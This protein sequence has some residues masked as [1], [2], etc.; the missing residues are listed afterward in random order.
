MKKG[1]GIAL[2]RQTIL[3]IL[4]ILKCLLVCEAVVGWRACL[5]AARPGFELRQRETSEL[6]MPCKRRGRL[7]QT[8][9]S[10]ERPSGLALNDGADDTVS[11]RQLLY[12]HVVR[13]D[14]GPNP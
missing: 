9:R 10:A 5:L 3:K 1:S 6:H 2:Q 13:L 8:N 4:K 11:P 12:L 14:C 7:R